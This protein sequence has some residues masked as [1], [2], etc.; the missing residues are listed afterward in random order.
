MLENIAS[1][2]ERVSHLIM[3]FTPS[4]LSA[5]N[6]NNFVGAKAG[7]GQATNALATGTMQMTPNWKSGGIFGQNDF[8]VTQPI[9][10]GQFNE[11]ASNRY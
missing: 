8:Y 7:A 5:S 10:Y 2:V 9:P 3:S 1:N 4:H 11:I 6:I